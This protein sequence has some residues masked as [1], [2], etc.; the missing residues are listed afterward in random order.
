MV[1]SLTKGMFLCLPTLILSMVLLTL[2]SPASIR[3]ATEVNTSSEDPLLKPGC[4]SAT[5][6]SQRLL[7]QWAVTVTTSK[8]FKRSSP[9][10]T[11]LST[12]E[13]ATSS[14][15]TSQE[16]LTS[17]S[18]STSVHSAQSLPSRRWPT[19]LLGSLKTPARFVAARMRDILD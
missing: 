8:S 7:P 2:L 16:T 3:M 5:A 18:G 14:T 11:P 9:M 19:S 6:E 10:E 17:T 4:E 15:S 1:S 12:S 13:N